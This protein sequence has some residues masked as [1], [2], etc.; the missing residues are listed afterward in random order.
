MKKRPAIFGLVFLLTLVSAFHLFAAPTDVIT[1]TNADLSRT[2][3]LTSSAALN[4]YLAAVGD[5]IT[6]EYANFLRHIGLTAPP[7]P[8][9]N[10]L[11]AVPDRIAIQYGNAARHIPLTNVPA[12]LSARLSAAPARLTLQYA[13]RNRQFTLGYPAALIGDITPPIIIDGPSA[14]AG[15]SGGA[16]SWTTDEFAT[17]ELHYGSSPGNYPNTVTGTLFQAY[18]SAPLPGLDSGTYYYRITSTDLSGNQATSREYSF[19]TQ[20]FI[21]L[22]V[23]VR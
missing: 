6:V 22:P 2:S 10:L 12:A 21:Y 7:A 13:N 23:I 1:V 19:R 11:N 17:Y 9:N 16:I 5:K 14:S 20:T 8:L 18:H 15:S 3:S 4:S